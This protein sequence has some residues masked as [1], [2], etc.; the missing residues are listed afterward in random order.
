MNMKI[1]RK[2]FDALIFALVLMALF[3]TAQRAFASEPA[4][5]GIWS[6]NQTS[7]Q[8]FIGVYAPLVDPAIVFF[9]FTH[10]E[11]GEQAWFISENVPIASSSP[12]TMVD[13]FKPVGRFL[14][15]DAARGDPVG[16]LAVGRSGQFLSVRFGISPMDGFTDACADEI[17][18]PV[19]PSPTPPPIPADLY[20]CQSHLLLTR[21]SPPIPAL[22]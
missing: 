1:F 2:T 17:T 4:D 21:I 11:S 10:D 14:S 5:N 15:K 16:V 19:L 7:S 13:I 20:P 22:M 3:L 6:S 8:G 12:E 9:W 18:T